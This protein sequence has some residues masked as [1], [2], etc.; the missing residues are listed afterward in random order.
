[1]LAMIAFSEATAY[2]LTNTFF[3]MCSAAADLDDAEQK[4]AKSVRRQV[5]EVIEDRNNFMHGEWMTGWHYQDGKMISDV[6]VLMRLKPARMS[7][8]NASMLFGPDAVDALADKLVALRREVIQ[9]GVNC[10]GP[11]AL[12]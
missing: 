1:M 5:L 6:T 7:D 10:L 12:P 9:F 2:P 3:A 4:T 11:V 8:P